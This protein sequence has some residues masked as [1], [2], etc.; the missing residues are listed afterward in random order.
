MRKMIHLLIF[1]C[2]AAILLFLLGAVPQEKDPGITWVLVEGG[3]DGD[4]KLSATEVTFDQYDQFC[5]ATEREKPNADFGRGKQPVINV[6]Y[7]DAVEYC[8]WLSDKTDKTVRLPNADEW[9]FA[10]KGGKLSKKFLFSG[11]NDA[12]EVAW[13]KD[14]SSARA[15]DVATKKPNELGL[16]DMSGNVWEWCDT[17]SIRSGGN[18]AYGGSWDLYDL[19]ARIPTRIVVQDDYRSNNLGFRVLQEQ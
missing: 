17:Y 9:V 6:T 8:K 4:F 18:W 10:A 3:P 12:E 5:D 7:D 14:N 11:S 15:H 1:A 13:I 19:H 16:Y 2:T